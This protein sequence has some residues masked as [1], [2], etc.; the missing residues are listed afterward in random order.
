[1]INQDSIKLDKSLFLEPSFHM[2]AVASGLG[3]MG[4]TWFS[5]TLAHALNMLHQSVLLFDAN[6]GL[7]NTDFQLDIP[8]KGYLN[9]VLSREITLNQAIT[10]INRKKFDV[11]SG[12]AGSDLLEGVPLGRLQI[13]KDELSLIAQNYNEVVV[14]LPSSEKI[15]HNMLPLSNIILVCTHEPSN[16]VST[17]DFLQKNITSLSYKSLQIVI[18]Y[19]NSYEDGLRTYNTLQHACEQYMFSTPP[20]LGVIRR[21][22]RVRDAIRNHVLL[23]NRYPS[24]EAAEDVFNIAR[25]LY[26]E[27]IKSEF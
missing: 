20:L 2:T 1:M 16:L 4:K 26:A 13:L 22:T 10:P 5:I 9:Q 18:N 12:Q 27:E 24:S 23:L 17:Y 3:S 6:N 14:D 19:A 11:I 15:L 25:K 21:D 7:L 8:Y